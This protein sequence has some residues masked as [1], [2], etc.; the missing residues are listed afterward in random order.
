MNS[1]GLIRRR[2]ACVQKLLRFRYIMATQ[3]LNAGADLST[4]RDLPGHMH[5]TTTQRYCKVSNIKVQRDYNAAIEI[6]MQRSQGVGKN[7]VDGTIGSLII[8]KRLSYDA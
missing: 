7:D 4:I 8:E 1:I 3:L 2:S 6:I 5:I